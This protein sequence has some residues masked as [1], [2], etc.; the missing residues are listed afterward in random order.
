MKRTFDLLF[1]TIVLVAILPILAIIG[2]LVKLDSP[3]PVFFRQQRVGRGFRVF[4]MYKF[5][6]MIHD[7]SNTGPLITRSDDPRITR[8]GRIL[9]K[10]KLD[11][12]PQLLNVLKGDMS[13]V[14]PRPEVGQYVEI[15]RRDYEEI[16]TV[17]PGL[18]DLASINFHE[19]AE[20]LGKSDSW[21]IEYIHRILPEKIRLAK[22]YIRKSSLV[23]DIVLVFKT[24]KVLIWNTL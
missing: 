20:I 3:G 17:R 1:S 4:L 12:L 15:F 10:F 21:E 19:E 9:R 8:V 2:I 11:E 13:F 16:L 5:R 7:A 24:L 23:Y 22:D 18:T 14:G 6:T